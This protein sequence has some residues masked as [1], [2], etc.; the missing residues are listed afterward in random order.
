MSA[1][2][3]SQL[4]QRRLTCR[5]CHSREL[6]LAVEMEPIPQGDG[7]IPCDEEEAVSGLFPHPIQFC[8]Q[9]GHVQTGI[10]VDQGFIYDNYIWK[11]SIS[12]G[13]VDAYQDYAEEMVE[14]YGVNDQSYCLE[15][16]GNDGTFSSHMQCHGV[17]TLVVDPAKD[18][19]ELCK[20]KGVNVIVDYFGSELA[21]D[22]VSKKGRASLIIANHVFANINDVQAI[23]DGVKVALSE[24]GVFVLQVFYL[25][26]VIKD[27]LLENFNHEHPSYYYVKSL[28]QFFSINGMELFDVSRNETKGGS[29][30]CHVQ[31]SGG[32][33]RIHDSVQQFIQ[34]E[35][36][37]GLDKVSTYQ[38]L[39][40]H[41]DTTRRLFHDMFANLSA[42]ATVAAYGTSIGATIFL[43]QY[44]IGRYIN[45]FIDDDP[46]RHGL[47]T[48]GLHIPVYPPEKL[49]T[50]KPD[51]VVITA[52]LY[53]DTIIAKHQQYLQHG[54]KFI[55]F[56][57]QFRVIDSESWR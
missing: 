42:N 29:I 23:I 35:Q 37:L 4:F 50:D 45:Y 49:L 28:N 7:Y 30:R 5:L 55:V 1:T 53:A 15:I 8:L 12:P 13:L 11:T 3:A 19:A 44:D 40:N 9:C 39:R 2:P 25:Y 38:C 17:D 52:P 57:P 18:I 56:R 46:A 43:Y 6:A 47:K 20:E 54:G 33:H 51:Y 36:Q 41:I 26:D 27:N 24:Q 31:L 14:K 48:P 34:K 16:G 22:I 10:D 21:E 32:P